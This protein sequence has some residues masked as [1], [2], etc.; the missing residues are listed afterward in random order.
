MKFNEKLQKIRKEHNITQEGLADRLNVS[1]QA[2]SKWESGLAYPDTEKLI[3]ISKM[4]NIS[5]DELI[6]D[7]EGNKNSNNTKNKLF[8]IKETFD[9]ILNFIGKTLNMFWSMTFREKIKFII[10]MLLLVL[11][12][13][14]IAYISNNIILEIIRRLFKFIIPRNFFD[15]LIYL[16][17]TL[18]YVL[19]LILGSI[20][21][22][23]VLKTRYL[24]Y[25]VVISDESVKERIKEEPIKELKE[26]EYKV[27][28][29]DP[30]DSS[31]H[32][33]KKIGK[34][35]LICLKCLFVMISVPIIMTF[36]MFV[37]LFTISLSFVFSGL[38]FN[39]I[40]LT[41]LGIILFIYLIISFIYNIVFDRKN[42]YSK[43]FIVFIISIL[44]I[45]VG[46]G[47]SFTNASKF[48]IYNEIITSDNK[49]ITVPFSDNLIIKELNNIDEDNIVI[50]EGDD[51]KLDIM[52]YNN[53]II[54]TYTY[55]IYDYKSEL[56]YKMLNIYT[57]NN[58]ID[59]YKNILND[60]KDKK[61]NTYYFD[62]YDTYK[63]N[64]I[65]ISSDNLTKIREN[66]RNYYNN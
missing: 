1:R 27:V 11:G 17:D 5:L 19:W 52:A 31:M 59:V 7:T 66:N 16:F 39:G 63:I 54:N 23:R 22:I 43:I 48:N 32:L 10:E 64:K 34:L 9:I 29:R 30:A 37:I 4:F 62:N 44:F 53:G 25:Y 14:I 18:L 49:T 28:I 2:V 55:D 56:T 26:K 60:L 36:I 21:F 12:I 45:G 38:F 51:I 58:G 41:L 57:Y 42:N 8:N 15:Y 33:L 20:I 6:N 13:I 24:D 65:Y 46:I 3:Q 40:N 50:E 61:I 47:V 35:C